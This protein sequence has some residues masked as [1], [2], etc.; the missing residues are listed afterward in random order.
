MG[1]ETRAECVARYVSDGEI[2]DID[3]LA[4]EALHTPGHSE[5]SY[6][7]V[8]AD[9][10]FT[11]DTLLIRGTGRTDLGGDARQ[12]YDSLFGKLLELPG[13]CLVYPAHD[14]NGRYVS[15]IADERRCNPRLQ[16]KS[17]EEYASLMENVRPSDPRQMDLPEPP[18]LR[19]SSARMRELSAL[20]AALAPEELQPPASPF[21]GA[22]E[23]ADRRAFG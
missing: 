13:P 5:D 1:Q 22:G 20:R 9:R 16:V 7:F 21:G 11:G 6:S 3:G 15:S 2:I 23:S 17:A 19:A 8:L 4:L 18:D 12:Q 10:V 14:Y